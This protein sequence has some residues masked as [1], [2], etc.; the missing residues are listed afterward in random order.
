MFCRPGRC[1]KTRFLR[2]AA[3]PLGTSSTF[4][5]LICSQLGGQRAARC[6]TIRLC[7]S[8][9]FSSPSCFSFSQKCFP[10]RLA[11]QYAKSAQRPDQE[12]ADLGSVFRDSTLNHDLLLFLPFFLLFCRSLL[13]FWFSNCSALIA[14][15]SFSFVVISA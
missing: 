6:R 13:C 5:R 4:I 9:F 2:Q 11:H 10:R 1:F 3:L 7:C 8:L 12:T 14:D 15:V